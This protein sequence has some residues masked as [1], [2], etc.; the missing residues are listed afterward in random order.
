MAFHFL[1]EPNAPH[2]AAL[3]ALAEFIFDFSFHFICHNHFPYRQ[4]PHLHAR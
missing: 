1:I 4:T 2:A 3:R